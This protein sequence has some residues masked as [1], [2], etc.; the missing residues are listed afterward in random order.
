MSQQNP[1]STSTSTST[2][3]PAAPSSGTTTTGDDLLKNYIKTLMI[4]NALRKSYKGKC[5]S[6]LD[7]LALGSGDFPKL[8]EAAASALAVSALYGNDPAAALLY[9]NPLIYPYAPYTYPLE[10]SLGFDDEDKPRRRRRAGSRKAAR[11]SRSRRR[12]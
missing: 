11:K 7:V 6:P 10:V 2:G 1:T 3:T 4:S 12:R 9:P 5:A 8:T